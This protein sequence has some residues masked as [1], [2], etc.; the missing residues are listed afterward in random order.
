MDNIHNIHNKIK[1][2]TSTSENYS[3]FCHKYENINEIF[4]KFFKNYKIS[5]ISEKIDILLTEIFENKILLESLKQ[6]HF[7][8]F[9]YFKNKIYFSFEKIKE[10]YIKFIDIDDEDN[11]YISDIFLFLFQQDYVFE[12]NSLKNIEN[13][14][15]FFKIFISFVENK[16]NKL[17]KKINKKALIIIIKF[18]SYWL[19]SDS[20][21]YYI[22]KFAKNS[23]KFQSNFII[24]IDYKEEE[25]L[26]FLENVLSI[27]FAT[28]SNLKFLNDNFFCWKLIS[29]YEN[30][31]NFSEIYKKRINEFSNE[32]INYNSKMS[33]YYFQT[34]SNVIKN[35]KY[36]I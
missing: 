2:T 13:S 28:I 19:N 32:K 3:E 34:L 6:L 25:N 4:S 5:E 20:S 16:S 36:I 21:L 17:F 1:N 10:N 30:Q 27:E 14:L 11:N 7:F 29:F 23:I 9:L 12:V 22:H 33:D 15:N 35:F 24:N 26:E 31:Q 8:I 18:C